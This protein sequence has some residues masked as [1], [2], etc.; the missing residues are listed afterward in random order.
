MILEFKK[1]KSISKIGISV[2]EKYEINKVLKIWKPDIIQV[3]VNIFDQRLLQ[4]KFL[5]KIK[6]KNIEIH[7]RSCFLQG[8]LLQKSLK[9]GNKKS[10]IIFKKFTNWCLKN[11]VSKLA[12]CISFIKNIK[13]IDYLIAGF[14]NSTHLN[15]IIDCYKKQLFRVP[16]YFVNNEKKIIDPRKWSIN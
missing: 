13:D 2:Y 15:E 3:P 11:N 4:N 5:K 12:A 14:D 16:N 10:K 7:A 1:K 6:H 8:L 9:K